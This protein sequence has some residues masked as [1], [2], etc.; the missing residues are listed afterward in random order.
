VNHEKSSNPRPTYESKGRI[1]YFIP[2]FN[3]LKISELRLITTKLSKNYKLFSLLQLTSQLLQSRLMILPN[4]RH[5]STAPPNI[6]S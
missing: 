5:Q 2:V 4:L 6:F 1:S 3:R